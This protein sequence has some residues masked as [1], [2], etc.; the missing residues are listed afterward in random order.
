MIW[1]A[2]TNIVSAAAPTKAVTERRLRDWLIAH[3]QDICLS[4]ITICEI[5]DGIAKLVRTRA[6]RKA[7]ALSDWLDGLEADYAGRILP[8]D[9]EVARLAGRLSDRA[10]GAGITVGYPD[11]LIA[12]TAIHHGLAVV[13]RNL[14]HFTPLGVKA[15]DP[16]R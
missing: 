6:V 1:L 14:R 16:S 7:Q 11:L 3:Q 10:R 15:V 13:T 12:A 8:I 5:E 9:A 4:V 2:D